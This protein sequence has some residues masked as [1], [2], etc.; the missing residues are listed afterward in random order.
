M[1]HLTLHQIVE[2]LVC[3]G[4]RERDVYSHEDNYTSE[5]GYVYEIGESAECLIASEREY[6]ATLE[7]E[8][9]RRLA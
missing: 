6:Q 8:L 2:A 1:Q 4:Q 9:E 5:D 7:A 3:S